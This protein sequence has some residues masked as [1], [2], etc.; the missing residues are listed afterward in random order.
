MS[1]KTTAGGYTSSSLP[2]GVVSI[3]GGSGSSSY[4]VSSPSYSAPSSNT[5]NVQNPA[6]VTAHTAQSNAEIAQSKADAM[7]TVAGRLSSIGVPALD[8]SISR[9]QSQAA[10]IAPPIYYANLNLQNMPRPYS[11]I[12][13]QPSK[14]TYISEAQLRE[15]ARRAAMT[16]LGGIEPTEDIIGFYLGQ[17]RTE[18]KARG[19]IIGEPPSNMQIVQPSTPKSSGFDYS[20]II[21]TGPAPPLYKGENKPFDYTKIISPTAE[22]KWTETKTT[23]EEL[24]LI[25]PKEMVY[26]I[27]GSMPKTTSAGEGEQYNITAAMPELKAAGFDVTQE[28]ETLVAKKPIS[29]S[30]TYK[31]TFTPAAA[32]TTVEPPKDPWVKQFEEGVAGVKG[33]FGIK[34]FF[35]GAAGFQKLITDIETKQPTINIEGFNI[36]NPIIEYS[37]SGIKTAGYVF[38]GG[39]EFALMGAVAVPLAAKKISAGQVNTEQVGIGLIGLGGAIALSAT[40]YG[41]RLKTAPI[42]A[43]GEI[44]G[45]ILGTAAFSGAVSGLTEA[46]SNALLKTFPKEPTYTYSEVR[47]IAEIAT[48][49]GGTRVLARA[50]TTAIVPDEGG[51][52]SVRVLE[53]ATQKGGIIK[54][55]AVGEGGLFQ[56][57][58]AGGYKFIGTLNEIAAGSKT[59]QAPTGLYSLTATSGIMRGETPYM[60]STISKE[61][62]SGLP[63][64]SPEFPTYQ[65][66]DIYGIRGA[67]ITP[68]SK[69]IFGGIERSLTFGGGAGAPADIIM[70]TKASYVSSGGL[71]QQQLTSVIGGVKVS[72]GLATTQTAQTVAAI[73]SQPMNIPT[74]PKLIAPSLPTTIT[75]TSTITSEKYL[76]G[77]SIET[78]SGQ[79]S[80]QLQIPKMFITPTEATSFRQIT[81]PLST[82]RTSTSQILGTRTGGITIP[83]QITAQLPDISFRQ[84]AGTTSGTAQELKK[85]T[86]QQQLTTQQTIPLSPMGFLPVIPA[87][88]PTKFPPFF[89]PVPSGAGGGGLG[90]LRRLFGK[91][92]KPQAS[93]GAAI[94]KIYG[95]TPKFSSGISFRALSRPTRTRRRRR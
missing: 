58:E 50:T 83:A 44:G 78:V 36:K 76:T 9:L 43:L 40:Q 41:E 80:A 32:P 64:I 60:A 52:I 55:T 91:A 2:S 79:A 92:T 28:G 13:A 85:I 72:Q 31:T 12:S 69:T 22:F 34:E 39:A 88:T 11:A 29:T 90:D 3:S 1:G 84:I 35:S 62:A 17:L 20:N 21:P 5:Y 7:R 48:A 46:G 87:L 81:S 77:F 47:P 10:A 71:I 89:P 74:M 82:T 30:T 6:E 95:K 56:P 37:L 93:L 33:T 51:Y 24:Y 57:T 42:S 61:I 94:L 54:W 86:A 4:T 14:I 38:S 8:V 27:T 53:G 66:I 15:D 19:E 68:T 25:T 70:P 65:G 73:T 18:A 45:T 49:E 26:S 16:S 63:T 75:K 23:G 59:I 67:V